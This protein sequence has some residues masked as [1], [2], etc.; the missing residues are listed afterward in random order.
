MV[1]LPAGDPTTEDLADWAELELIFGDSRALGAGRLVQLFANA[2]GDDEPDEQILIHEQLTDEDVEID[3]RGLRE[4]L[5]GATAAGDSPS[6]RRSD[7]LLQEMS[8]RSQVI[9]SSYPISADGN[10][11]Q[12]TRQWVDD[13]L[14]AFLTLVG[15]RLELKL[16]IPFHE[17]ARLF[18]EVVTVALGRYVGGRSYRF[19]WPAKQGE[20]AEDFITKARRLS[21]RLGEQPGTMRNVSPAAKDYALDVVAWRPFAD[22]TPDE[23]TPGQV[24]VLCQCGIGQDWN[25]KTMHLR[26]WGEVIRFAVEPMAALAFP[27]TPSRLD[28]NLHLWHDVALSPSIPFDR[29]RIASLIT[30]DDLEAD[31]KARLIDWIRRFAAKLPNT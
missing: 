22:D 9:G 15:A 19:G 10:G 6:S 11:M 31:L 1:S 2:Y 8:F 3:L 28:D 14:Y 29:L 21:R 4:D 17:P 30:A 24:V 25:K 7:G 16:E 13:P 23:P 18:E 20:P 26:K 27:H 12:L 5:R